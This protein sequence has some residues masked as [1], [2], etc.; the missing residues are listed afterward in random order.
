ME[1]MEHYVKQLNLPATEEQLIA[2]QFLESRGQ[3]FLIDFGYE[4]AVEKAD[5]LF[6]TECLLLAVESESSMI[7]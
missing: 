1:S 5:E 3:R 2:G 7:Q 6:V 4:N